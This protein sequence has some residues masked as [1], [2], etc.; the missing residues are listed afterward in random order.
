VKDISDKHVRSPPPNKSSVARRCL[1]VAGVVFLVLST[2]PWIGV[3]GGYRFAIPGWDVDVPH[4][5]AFGPDGA[6][7]LYGALSLPLEWFGAIPVIR[8]VVFFPSSGRVRPFS[9]FVVWFLLGFTLT[10][11]GVRRRVLGLATPPYSPADSE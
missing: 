2:G 1:I 9:V 7:G 5:H 3:D 6:P 8:E 10:W 11:F 4:L